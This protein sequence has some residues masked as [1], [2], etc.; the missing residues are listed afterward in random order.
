MLMKKV[1]EYSMQEGCTV[2]RVRVFEPNVGPHQ[3]HQKL[4][5]RD[6]TIDL[7]KELGISICN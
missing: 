3:L 7:I 2:S 4:G 6:K 5:Y 1:E